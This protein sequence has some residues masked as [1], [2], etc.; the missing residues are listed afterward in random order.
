MILHHY[1]NAVQNCS[2][3]FIYKLLYSMHSYKSNAI[4]ITDLN[5]FARKVECIST[6]FTLSKHA[7]MQKMCVYFS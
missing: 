4:E 5:S 6:Q 1:H 3:C 7:S 2:V